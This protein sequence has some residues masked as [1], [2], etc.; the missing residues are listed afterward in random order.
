MNSSSSRA[1]VHDPKKI[2]GIKSPLKTIFIVPL[3]IIKIF[4]HLVTPL[5]MLLEC[6][7][8][9]CTVT[10]S[11]VHSKMCKASNLWQL[12]IIFSIIK[13]IYFNI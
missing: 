10:P 9:G 2:L 4:M 12:H 8:E 5:E 6:P 7:D 1:T 13:N 3:F 11:S